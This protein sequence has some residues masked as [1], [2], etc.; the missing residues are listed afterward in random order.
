MHVQAPAIVVR[1]GERLLKPDSVDDHG[2]IAEQAP[3]ELGI[4]RTGVAAHVPVLAEAADACRSRNPDTGRR[5]GALG[6]RPNHGARSPSLERRVTRLHAV[7]AMRR[8]LRAGVG[9][10]QA[11]EQLWGGEPVLAKLRERRVR[12]GLTHRAEHDMRLP[13]NAAAI[14]ATTSAS[15]AASSNHLR[16]R[17]SSSSPWSLRSAVI[18]AHSE[19]QWGPSPGGIFGFRSVTRYLHGREMERSGV[20]TQDLSC[21]P[22]R[23]AYPPYGEPRPGWSTVPS[24][25]PGCRRQ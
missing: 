2:L 1:I 21:Y 22:H 15:R 18:S 12:H 11:G 14:P 4:R 23:R 5:R 25:A 6:G 20:S 10:L 19:R 3:L 9:E 17:A 16:S 13:S 8:G 7:I 24:A